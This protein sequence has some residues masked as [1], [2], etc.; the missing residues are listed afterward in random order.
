MATNS[1]VTIERISPEVLEIT[2]RDSDG[3]SHTYRVES[4]TA[5]LTH[6]VLNLL[7]ESG[8]I[9]LDAYRPD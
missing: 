3:V 6:H 7:H 2:E 5:S 4:D 8:L 9:N 1:K